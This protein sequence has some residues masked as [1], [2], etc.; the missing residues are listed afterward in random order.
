MT[1]KKS[2]IKVAQNHL[3]GAGLAGRVAKAEARALGTKPKAKRAVAA[4]PKV[5]T[6]KPKPKHVAARKARIAAAT[7]ADRAAIAA[8]RKR[9]K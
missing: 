3:S 8:R 4:K 7:A 1:K 2:P 9:G 6:V 5:A